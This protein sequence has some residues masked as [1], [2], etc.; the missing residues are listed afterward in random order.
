MPSGY[1]P[2]TWM[3][4]VTKPAMEENIGKDFANIYRNSEQYRYVKLLLQWKCDK[5]S[6]NIA[7][8]LCI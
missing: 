8:V 3:L 5:A 6:S 7:S 2:A 4:E 1:N